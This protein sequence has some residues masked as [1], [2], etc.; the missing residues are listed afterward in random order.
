MKCDAVRMKIEEWFN[1]NNINENEYY[2][3]LASLLENIDKCANTASVYGAF[4][5]DIKKTALKLLN[6]I[7]WK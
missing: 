6:I 3:L 4:L 7:H 5:K 2:F 1:N